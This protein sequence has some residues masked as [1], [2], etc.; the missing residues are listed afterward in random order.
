MLI[1]LI[2]Y[3]YLVGCGAALLTGYAVL[4]YDWTNGR[5]PLRGA[6]LT[7]LWPISIPALVFYAVLV[8]P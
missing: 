2:I 7:L 1:A 3:L 8:G 4:E 5:Y 6:L